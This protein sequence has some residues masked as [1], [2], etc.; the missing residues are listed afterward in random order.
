M[1]S[2]ANG[3]L[4]V[5]S[6]CSNVIRT[7]PIKGGYELLS[8]VDV[9]IYTAVLSLLADVTSK[10]DFTLCITYSCSCRVQQ[11]CLRWI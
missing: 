10:V 6:P 4:T 3:G 9:T 7:V 8:K 11:P 2:P 5:C 1:Y